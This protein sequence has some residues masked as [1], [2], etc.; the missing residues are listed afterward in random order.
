MATVTHEVFVIEGQFG[1]LDSGEI[2]A[3][4]ADWSNGFVAPMSEGVL[5]VTGINT[6][7]VRVTIQGPYSST[8]DQP[9]DD[10]EEIV[11]AS[12]HAPAGKLAVDSPL[13]GPLADDSAILS[14][15]GPAWYRVRVH[16]RG[17]ALHP[18]QVSME[19]VEDYLIITWPAP[20]AETT[21]MRAS[22]A[23]ERSLR[24]P[25][26]ERTPDTDTDLNPPS[27]KPR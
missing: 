24:T 19:P 17:R 20:P 7:L 21:I 26:P 1:L 15:A 16:A 3:H 8:P 9:A 4:S 13:S 27:A 23:I 2:P 12:V 18:D 25:Q 10:W 5:I 22:D 11:E 14:P 6:G